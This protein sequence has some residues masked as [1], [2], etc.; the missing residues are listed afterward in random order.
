MET[1]EL[2]D[3]QGEHIPV[4]EEGGNL[5]KVAHALDAKPEPV[6]KEVPPIEKDDVVQSKQKLPTEAHNAATWTTLPAPEEVP[7][8]LRLSQRSPDTPLAPSLEPSPHSSEEQI[9]HKTSEEEKRAKDAESAKEASAPAPT[10]APVQAQASESAPQ[11]P[12]E[13]KILPPKTPEKARFQQD[14]NS[15]LETPQPPAA[16]AM[17]PG[18]SSIKS[19]ANLPG[20]Y[21][22]TPEKPA[23]EEEQQQSSWN[24]KSC[25]ISKWNYLGLLLNHTNL[26][27][28]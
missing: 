16:P 9:K 2:V 10:P 7:T 28:V 18:N 14:Q 19:A 26:V 6:S 25:L 17:S 5:S 12:K 24:K 23:Q 27:T 20:G 3:A 1:V 11:E 22:Q 4:T 15:H 21:Q 13:D 8:P